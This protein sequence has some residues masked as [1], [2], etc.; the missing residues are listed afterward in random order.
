MTLKEMFSYQETEEIKGKIMVNI[1]VIKCYEVFKKVCKRDKTTT[2]V[3][4]FL[5]FTVTIRK[6]HNI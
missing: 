6:F 5:S 2:A 3:Y 1:L 4:Q